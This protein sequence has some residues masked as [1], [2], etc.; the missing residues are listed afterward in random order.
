MSTE[1][2]ASEFLCANPKNAVHRQQEDG[3]RKQFC[4]RFTG[5]SQ[6]E[7]ELLCGRIDSGEWRA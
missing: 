3:F 5:G 2:A 7:A 1:S 6:K 4:Y